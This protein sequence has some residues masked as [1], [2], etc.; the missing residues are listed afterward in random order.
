MLDGGADGRF[1]S[2][3]VMDYLPVP[4]PLADDFS[5]SINCAGLGDRNALGLLDAETALKQ[6][7]KVQPLPVG[8]CP[9]GTGLA[10]GGAAG[11][12]AARAAW[13]FPLPLW[14]PLPLPLAA[15]AWPL[16]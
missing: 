7:G 5:S 11:A 15:V 10:G 14:R 6:G 9:Q 13:P 4:L 16:S 12:G 3:V 8:N 2:P 1:N